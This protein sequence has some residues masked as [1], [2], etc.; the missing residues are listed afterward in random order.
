MSPF[1]VTSISSLPLEN[2]IISPSSILDYVL[3]IRSMRL[4]DAAIKVRALCSV[5][6]FSV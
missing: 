2:V 4:V 6:R 3:S 5:T 1:N